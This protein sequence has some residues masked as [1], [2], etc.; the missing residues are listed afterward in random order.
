ME[1]ETLKKL[2]QM[3]K[4][5]KKFTEDEVQKIFMFYEASEFADKMR[6]DGIEFPVR[7]AGPKELFNK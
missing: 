5:S 7:K 1:T 6:R 3:A 2:W 4:R